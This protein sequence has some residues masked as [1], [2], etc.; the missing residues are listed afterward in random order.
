M[1]NIKFKEIHKNEYYEQYD[2]HNY[3]H[4]HNYEQK[5]T[6]N[7]IKY[8]PDDIKIY[9]LRLISPLKLVF[10]NKF[11]YLKFHQLYLLDKYNTYFESIELNQTTLFNKIIPRI[12]RST[13][14]ENINISNNFYFSKIFI[15]ILINS[16]KLNYCFLLNV[17]LHDGEVILYKIE[18]QM[19]LNEHFCKWLNLTHK[20]SIIIYYVSLYSYIKFICGIYKPSKNILKLLDIYYYN[21]YANSNDNCDNYIK[22]KQETIQIIPSILFN[23]NF[24][25]N[26]EHYNEEDDTSDKSNNIINNTIMNNNK[27]NNSNIKQTYKR[28]DR[29]LKKNQEQERKENTKK[30]KIKNNEWG[31]I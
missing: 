17:L 31:N 24:N 6:L 5:N 28:K 18:E 19:K 15:K 9:I 25:E 23:N 13:I 26:E 27:P 2:E 7:Y 22:Q 3:E 10:I 8:L 4:E 16:I 11:F 12:E 29:K 14:I 30:L 1:S 21:N 20:D